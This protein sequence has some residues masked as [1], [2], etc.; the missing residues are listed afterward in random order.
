MKK[1]EKELNRA[2]QMKDKTNIPPHSCLNS[3]NQEHKQ[4]Q[5]LMRV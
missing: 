4:Q 3:Y 2:K 5:M 1:W